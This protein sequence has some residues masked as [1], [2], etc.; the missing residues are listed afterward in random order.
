MRVQS[1]SAPMMAHFDQEALSSR[2]GATGI[3]RGRASRTF[4]LL[5]SL[6]LLCAASLGA[7]TNK[8]LIPIPP[9]AEILARLRQPHPRLLASLDDFGQLKKRI[10]SATL[11]Q[12]ASWQAAL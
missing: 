3:R 9:A 4:R 2:R 7:E 12:L 6:V 10:N 1:W 8:A 5:L 11:P